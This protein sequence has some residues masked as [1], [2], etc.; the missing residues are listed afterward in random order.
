LDDVLEIVS[1]KGLDG[2]V[3]TNTTA[4]RPAGLAAVPIA[5]E[6]GGLSGALL[7]ERSTQ[8]IASIYRKTGGKLPILG[9]GGVF[10]AAEAWEKLA[11]GASAV[12]LYTGFVYGGPCIVGEIA[13]GLVRLLDERKIRD[14]RA[15]IGSEVSGP[16]RGV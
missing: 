9:V 10:T 11:A 14:L 12:E 1:E 7:R 3:A 2:I 4:T 13:R 8:V 15:V 5:S 6:T 16:R